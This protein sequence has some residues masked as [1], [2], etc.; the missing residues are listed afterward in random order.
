MFQSNVAT[1]DS[2][3]ILGKEFRYKVTRKSVSIQT[4]YHINVF[5]V[6]L[7]DKLCNDFQKQTCMTAMSLTPHEWKIH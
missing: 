2:C 4:E 5:A 7:L 3:C 6:L 1:I